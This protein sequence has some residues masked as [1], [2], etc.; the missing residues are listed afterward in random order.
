MHAGIGLLDVGIVVS[1]G[2]IGL[3][4]VWS[5]FGILG[6]CGLLRCDV[7]GSCRRARILCMRFFRKILPI[8]AG[9]RK[10]I[11]SCTCSM[12]IA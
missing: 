3:A 5:I 8:L 4:M 10:G 7:T 6:L 2:E 9:L 1:F 11:G 12:P